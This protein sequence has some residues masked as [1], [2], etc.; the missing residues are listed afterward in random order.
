[1]DGV[2]IG[3]NAPLTIHLGEQL[4]SPMKMDEHLGESSMTDPEDIEIKAEI[5]KITHDID[6]I[7]KNITKIV[8]LND[9]IDSP[10]MDGLKEGK[11]YPTQPDTEYR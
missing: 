8:P 4:N 6:A 3:K 10:G 2:L 11:P 5:D 1:M 7:I 9:T